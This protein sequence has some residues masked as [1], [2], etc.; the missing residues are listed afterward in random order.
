[1]LGNYFHSIQYFVGGFFLTFFFAFRLY[2]QVDL[3][4]DICTNAMSFPILTDGVQTCITTTNV[5]AQGE[6]PYINQGSCFSSAGGITDAPVPAADVWYQFTAVGNLI[7]VTITTDD[8]DTIALSLYEGTCDGLIGRRCNVAFSSPLTTSLAPVSPGTSYYLQISGGSVGDVGEFDICLRNYEN[9][10]SLCIS[11]QSLMVNPPPILGAYSVGQTVE[12]CIT[13]GHYEQ[14]ASDWFHGMVPIF[15]SGWDISTL[16]TDAAE[17]CDGNGEW[18]WYSSVTGTSS[19]NV[20]AQGPGFFYDSSA[21]GAFDG[22]PGNN[23]GDS[24]NGNCNWLFCMTVTT[25]NSCPPGQNGED[26]SIVFLNYSD[27]ETGSWNASNSPCPNDPNFV[28]K[29]V[30]ACCRAPEMTGTPPSCAD[31]S[32]SQIIAAMTEGEAPFTFEWSNG[33]VETSDEISTL[34]GVPTGFYTLTVTDND[35][36]ESQAS[37]TL[38]SS[39]V[40]YAT[41]DYTQGTTC[42]SNGLANI[43]AVGATPPYIYILDA[44]ATQNNTGQFT[45]LAA[46]DHEVTVQDSGG[47]ITILPFNIPDWG[48]LNISVANVIGAGCTDDA[49]SILIATNAGVPPYQYSIANGAIQTAPLFSGLSSGNYTVTVT[50]LLGCQLT[51]SVTI[52]GPDLLQLTTTTTLTPCVSTNNGS[53]LLQA[54]GGATPYTYSISS[55][56]TP[57]YIADSVFSQLAPN[58]YTAYARDANGCDLP[59]T[60]FNIPQ[61]NLLTIDLGETQQVLNNTSLN[62]NPNITSGIPTTYTWHASS[63]SLSCTDCPA[64]TLTTGSEPITITLEIRDADNCAAF[65]TLLINIISK[66]TLLVPSSFSPNGDGINDYFKPIAQNLVGGYTLQIYNRWGQKIFSSNSNSDSM[67]WS[68]FHK[69]QPAPIGVYVYV[70]QY[71]DENNLPQILSGNVFLVR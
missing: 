61:P 19:N 48:S 64:P 16:T 41:L 62:L 65:D 42:G 69:E 24:G 50:D 71:T 28:F 23:Y 47:C 18:G 1:M 29:A 52:E 32:T 8:L 59:T 63:G 4:N 34:N 44:G 60:T 12:F 58:T 54:S 15:G 37:Y 31:P 7:D 56:E 11:D 39:D 2:A 68:G 40:P 36:C 67:G 5:G 45:D 46:G 70:I 53:V 3:P 35:N 26:L 55:G 51:A 38:E 17:P 49:G 43:S 20:G 25:K 6:L 9:P 13:I 57:V 66:T 10:Q 22:N 30:L 21:G 27:S 14:N 33:F